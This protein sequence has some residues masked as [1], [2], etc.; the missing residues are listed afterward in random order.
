M[1]HLRRGGLLGQLRHHRLGV[2][3]LLADKG[4]EGRRAGHD[5][6]RG[7]DRLH[8]RR[9]HLAQHRRAAVH[10][11]LQRQR[12]VCPGEHRVCVVDS[13]Y[14]RQGEQE[15]CCGGGGGAG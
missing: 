5:Q 10:D 12:R 1:L 7:P 14:A 4:E 6:R 2:Q 9:L 3:H 13:G 11:R 8:L 15:D